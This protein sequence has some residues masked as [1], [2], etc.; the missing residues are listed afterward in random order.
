[1]ATAIPIEVLTRAMAAIAKINP[2]TG[3]LSNIG[4]LLWMASGTICFFWGSLD[5]S[6][7]RQDS[8]R[9]FL[10]SGS[11]TFVLLF[12]DFFM[13]HDYLAE[14]YFHIDE[15]AVFAVCLAITAIYALRFR[16]RILEDPYAICF[17]SALFWFAVS[18]ILDV[19]FEKWLSA[20]FGHWYYFLEDGTKFVGLACWC[21]FFYLSA[22]EHMR[23]E[24]PSQSSPIETSYERR[25]AA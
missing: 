13:F 15:K 9:F 21:A 11:L 1:M 16:Y 24:M 19:L 4:I 23:S 17:L 2:L 5:L 10:A 7:G 20:Q 3:W 8:A 25:R 12:D 22:F 6:R 14:Q 18:M